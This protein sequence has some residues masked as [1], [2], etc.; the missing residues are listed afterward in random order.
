M[1]NSHGHLFFRSIHTTIMSTIDSEDQLGVY[2][3]LAEAAVREAVLNKGKVVIAWGLITLTVLISGLYAPKTYES[4]STLY[5][6]QQSIITPL[7]AGQAAVT[8]VENH[9]R[10][11]RETVQ[12]PTIMRQVAVEVGLI[13]GGESDQ[14][15]ERIINDLRG[16]INITA[17]GPSYITLKYSG[18][19]AA[20][21]FHVVT[22][23][24]DAFV[25][26][27]SENKKRESRS[28]YEFIS[29]QAK[30]YKSQLVTAD[31]ALKVFKEKNTD[32]NERMVRAKIQ[33]LGDQVED[34]KLDIGERKAKIAS[35]TGELE[36]ERRVIV[37]EQRT[38]VYRERLAQLKREKDALLLRFTESH[39]DIAELN[40]QMLALKD[41]IGSVDTP[42]DTAERGVEDLNPVFGALRQSL[43]SEKVELKSSQRRLSATQGLLKKEQETLLRV[44][45]Y[46]TEFSELNRDYGV[47]KDIYEDMLARKEKA[48]LSMV[49][50]IEEQGVNYSIQEPALYPQTPKGIQFS[51]FAIGAPFA[52]LLI[53][54]ALILAYVM[55]DPRVRVADK[56][57]AAFDIPV[58]AHVPH[59]YTPLTTRLFEKDMVR[60]VGFVVITGLV[61]SAIIAYKFL[62]YV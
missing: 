43:L 57:E 8:K 58:I 4:S 12:S 37:R 61:Y 10:V 29:K 52:G 21:V 51:Y 2:L 13:K 42:P 54:L 60:V 38:D 47:T 16:T 34:I 44:V 36:G 55:L 9:S 26:H 6:N 59:V 20:E 3:Q 7:L 49:L 46:G 53:V 19:S 30:S 15:I 50:D 45:A 14:D 41:S 40:F 23:I 18:A 39:P 48:R 27:V 25:N 11:V 22:A 17:I 33:R 56:L 32:G 24:T 31:N 28:A 62:G 5:V 1:F 35:L